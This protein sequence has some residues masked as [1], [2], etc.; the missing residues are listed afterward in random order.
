METHD[1]LLAD[2]QKII[3]IHRKFDLPVDTV[4]K[5][6]SE[7]ASCKKWWGPKDFTCPHCSIDFKV[8]GKYLSCMQAPDGKQFW[9]TGVYKEI[10]PQRKIVFTDNF[11]DSKGNIKSA[12]DLNM[13]GDWPQELSITVTLEE[14]A[15]KT[16]L[17]L[18]HVGIPEEMYDEC[19]QGWQ[20]SFDKLERN[21]K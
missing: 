9:S 8:G 16:D 20:E 5:A 19:I 1:N 3:S 15:G 18:Q 13:P 21:L 14:V 10:I 17:S 7:P 2:H 11:A 4:W 12:S 6:W